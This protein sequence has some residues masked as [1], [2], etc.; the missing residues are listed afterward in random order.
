MVTYLTNDEWAKKKGYSSF[1]NYSSSNDYPTADGLTAMRE[2]SCG[3][4]NLLI[5]VTTNLTTNTDYLRGLEY[6]MVELMIDEEQGRG[7]EEGRPQ[8][9]PRDYIYE[10][11]R[12]RLLSLDGTLNRGVHG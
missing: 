12:R 10:R 8:Y 9:I 5:G 6:R 4:I 7:T 3:T 1:T 11:D 2:E